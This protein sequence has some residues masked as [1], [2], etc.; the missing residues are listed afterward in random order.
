MTDLDLRIK[1]AADN[2]VLARLSFPYTEFSKLRKLIKPSQEAYD[3][4][5]EIETRVAKFYE[6]QDYIKAHNIS[7]KQDL[8]NLR[9][10]NEFL[11]K[12][13]NESTEI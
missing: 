12:T 11:L 5:N 1:Q 3:L 6:S 10:E 13:I 9:L 2:A 4:L 8:E 7:L